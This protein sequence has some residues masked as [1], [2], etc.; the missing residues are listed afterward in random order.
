MNGPRA[1]NPT[2]AAPAAGAKKDSGSSAPK[3]QSPNG[4]KSQYQQDTERDNPEPS[5]ADAAKGSVVL[6]KC[7]FLT[8]TEKLLLNEEFEMSVSVK[9]PAEVKNR[10]AAFD[11]FCTR[12][13]NGKEERTRIWAKESGKIAKEEADT[14][15]VQAKAVLAT[16]SDYVAGETVKFQLEATHDQASAPE[17]S[18]VVEVALKTQAHWIGGDDLFFR[19]DGE[20]PL[21]KED[22]SLIQVLTTA[23]NRVTKPP[24]G[25]AETVICFGFASSAGDPNP[26][27]KLSL[28]RAQVVKAILDRDAGAWD[29]LAKGNFTTVDIQQFLSD[30]HKA[31]GWECDPGAVDGQSGPKTKAGIESFQRECNARYKLGLKED[32]V[33]GP[34]TWG[35]VLR[36]IHGQVQDAL[37]QDPSKE[38]SWAKPKWGHGGKGVYA[39][40]EDFATGGDKP[41]ERSV[42]IT[43]FSP[44]SEPPLVDKIDAPVTESDNRTQNKQLVV[45]TKADVQ[46]GEVKKGAPKETDTD[47]WVFYAPG[48]DQYLVVSDPAEKD[49]LLA[50]INKWAAFQD[51]VRVYRESMAKTGVTQ[52][53]IKEG[54]KL[55]EEADKGL[56]NLGK[57]PSNAIQELL[58]W[59]G[60]TRKHT[61][62][63][64]RTYIGPD[65]IKDAS[66]KGNWKK[67]D[68]AEVKKILDEWLKKGESEPKSKTEKSAKLKAVLWESGSVDKQWP[69][70]YKFAAK[71]E[72]QTAAGTFSGSAEAQFFR[73]VA[74]ADAT[75]EFDLKEKKLQVGAKGGVSYALADGKADGSWNIPS[76]KGFDLYKNL[77]LSDKARQAIKPNTQCL[78][79]FT[80]KVEGRAF[81]GASI[82]GA[83]MLPA[84]ELKD[85][86]KAAVS[87]SG[88]AFAG[89]SAEG[90]VSGA[91]EWCQGGALDK[92]ETLTAVAGTAAGN[93]GIG[94]EGKIEFSYSNGKVKF[95]AGA[96]V[97]FGLGGKLGVEYELDAKQAINL[98]AHLFE[99]VEWRRVDAITLAAFQFYLNATFAPIVVGVKAIEKP[100]VATMSDFGNWLGDKAKFAATLANLKA[101]TYVGTANQTL[102]RAA[103]PETLGRVLQV[104]TEAFQIEDYD[105]IINVLSATQSAHELKWTL[106][107]AQRSVNL[108]SNPS[109][110]AKTDALSLGVSRLRN[111]GKGSGSHASYVGRLNAILR[112]KGIES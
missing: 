58:L 48:R 66:S 99:S 97:T 11:L 34:K 103:P 46:R 36:A 110:K 2:S 102:L 101:T 23:I 5:A 21:L 31:C 26:N 83:I 51:K 78:F 81:V 4:G 32:G 74:G 93:A 8:P 19:N 30:L 76:D 43:F 91:L 65:K 28:R 80:V 82:T 6:S 40:G 71:G 20:F 18:A 109:E 27:R 24:Q 12:Q 52:E 89:A 73:F 67:N 68:D 49:S 61:P 108:D 16:P 17:P 70:K 25:D 44:G 105:A 87:G 53:K 64:S 106:R 104:L 88:A 100:L 15:E 57:D 47:P 90:K 22:G 13:R 79:R 60:N 84:I 41:E 111:H 72:K 85:G 39:N 55:K 95:C 92:F 7:Q 107:Y 42:Q 75:A 96:M 112:A 33:C 35:A 45:K 59:K 63:A 94:A 37:G 77:M 54:E 38:P 69:W 56:K 29:S 10:L 3:G 98:F 50:D 86:Q 62:I 14:V 1:T 9:A